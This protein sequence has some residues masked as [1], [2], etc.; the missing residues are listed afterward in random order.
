MMTMSV[1]AYYLCA[2]IAESRQLTHTQKLT[3]C[4][5]KLDV[6]FQVAVRAANSCPWRFARWRTD[7]SRQSASLEHRTGT[8][9]SWSRSPRSARANCQH[10]KAL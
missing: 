5:T 2:C 10:I 4:I 6:P 7:M 9:D 3:R 8:R 1:N